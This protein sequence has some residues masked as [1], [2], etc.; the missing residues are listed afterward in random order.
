MLRAC[1][2]GGR[3][4][5]E[6]PAMCPRSRQLQTDIAARWNRL[7]RR[8]IERAIGELSLIRG[9]CFGEW[10]SEEHYRSR[11]TRSAVASPL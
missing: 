2:I 1:S 5:N 4:H 9:A 11:S 3:H 6:S 7:D 8:A 10:R